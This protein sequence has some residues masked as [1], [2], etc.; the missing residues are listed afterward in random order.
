MI[1]PWSTNPKTTLDADGKPKSYVFRACF[2]DTFQARVLAKFVLN[3][4]H[5][6]TAAALYDVASEAPNGQA[7][8]FKQTFEENGGQMVAFETY[9]TGDRDFSA[10]LTKIKAANPDVIFPARLLQRRAAHRAAGAPPRHHRAARRQRRMEL[11]RDHQA[12]RRRHRRIVF[13]QPLLDPD[14]HA[15]R[16]EVHERLPGE[17]QPGPR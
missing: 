11:A 1:S 9:T 3:N 16:A 10:Q 17:I 5:A 2:I 7:T 15:R 12:R 6:K 4:L 13:L 14:R 8:L